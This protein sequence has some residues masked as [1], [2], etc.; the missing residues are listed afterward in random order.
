MTNL[1]MVE[2]GPIPPDGKRIPK[3]EMKPGERLELLEL[4][5]Y[6]KAKQQRD[7]NRKSQ[8]RSR[9]NGKHA[10]ELSVAK[11]ALADPMKYFVKSKL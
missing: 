4:K 9:M 5:L 1:Q 10:F 6:C 11:Y 8:R 3:R 2:A 7:Q